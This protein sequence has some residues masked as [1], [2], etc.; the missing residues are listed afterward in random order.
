MA[1][2]QD[3][4]GLAAVYLKSWALSDLGT[5]YLSGNQTE[6]QL[7][8]A[9]L[10]TDSYWHEELHTILT[11]IV[12]DSGIPIPENKKL[13]RW[14]MNLPDFFARADAIMA[15]KKPP[16]STRLL[17]ERVYRERIMEGYGHVYREL[18]QI[19]DNFDL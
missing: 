2:K 10:R 12:T 7:K 11:S 18:S 3:I 1:S 9:R 17:F 14:L 13:W 19:I 8:L 15:A 6:G 4:K 16:T 5:P